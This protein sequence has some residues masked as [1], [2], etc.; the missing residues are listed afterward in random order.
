MFRKCVGV[1]KLC[2]YK[3]I[4]VKSQ[5]CSQQKFG[6]LRRQAPGGAT[7]CSGLWLSTFFQRAED[8]RSK[9]LSMA[10]CCLEE[11]MG[12]YSNV[13]VSKSF[14]CLLFR[15]SLSH[16]W[17]FDLFR[18]LKLREWYLY[19]EVLSFSYHSSPLY[20]NILTF[21]P[22]QKCYSNVM[23]RKEVTHSNGQ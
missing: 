10:R 5:S 12:Q 17:R 1:M 20:C 2:I 6:Q 18:E 3:R 11:V 14:S 4:T 19:K 8:V 21:D 15:L 9:A 7:A 22:A 13:Q 16:C 23:H